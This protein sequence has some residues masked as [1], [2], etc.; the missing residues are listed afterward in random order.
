MEIYNS[1][2]DN[3]LRGQGIFQQAVADFKNSKLQ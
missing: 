2:N 3:N 1:L